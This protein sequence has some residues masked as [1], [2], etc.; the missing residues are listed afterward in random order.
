MAESQEWFLRLKMVE[1][2]RFESQTTMKPQFRIIQ[3]YGRNLYCQWFQKWRSVPHFPLLSHSG[4]FMETVPVRNIVVP[5][6][7]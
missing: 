6:I 1:S 3:D 7:L 5:L 2:W 4:C